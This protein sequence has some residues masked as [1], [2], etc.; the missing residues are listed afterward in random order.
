MASLL[1]SSCGDAPIDEAGGAYV[2][3]PRPEPKALS[4]PP[5]AEKAAISAWLLDNHPAYFQRYQLSCEVALARMALAFLGIRSETEDSLYDR[6]P[7]GDDPEFS[8]VC[9]DINGFR[10]DATSGEIVWENYGIH[11]PVIESLINT[12]LFEYGLEG[13]FMARLERLDDAALRLKASE[14]DEWL[15]CIFWIVGMQHRF[16]ANPPR[17]ADGLVLGQHVMLMAP[18]LAADGSMVC[19]DPYANVAHPAYLK[20]T[21]SRELF[22]Y[23]AV[24]LYRL[25]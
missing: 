14:D 21:K 16:G 20:E 3:G 8:V 5:I 10:F 11:A 1:A 25:P 13:R 22:S 9:P 18:E 19:Y 2:P 7:F 12:V 17:N 6:L 24:S 23:A 4:A 15:G